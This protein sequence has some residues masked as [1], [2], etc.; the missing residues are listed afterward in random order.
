MRVDLGLVAMI[1]NPMVCAILIGG[2]LLGVDVAALIAIGVVGY[3]AW[4]VLHAVNYKHQRNLLEKA[5]R[6]K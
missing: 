3:G 5:S 6:D 1:L 4:G 2:I